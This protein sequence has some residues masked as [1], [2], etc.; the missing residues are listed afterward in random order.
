MTRY[1]IFL[2]NLIVFLV[3]WLVALNCNCI[4][5]TKYLDVIK[6]NDI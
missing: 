6:G 2:F 3:L 4:K 5:E 1:S